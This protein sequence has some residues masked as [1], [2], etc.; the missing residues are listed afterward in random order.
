MPTRN[1]KDVRGY[2]DAAYLFID[3]ADFF[4]QSIQK[5]LE[6]AISAYEEKSNGKTI[7]VS[8]PN[9]PGGLFEKIEKDPIKVRKAIS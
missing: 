1:I 4:E 3:E 2:F 8:T 6:P 7:M 9:A 5:E